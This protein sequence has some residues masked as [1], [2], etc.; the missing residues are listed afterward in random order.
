MKKSVK[1]MAALLC[2]ALSLVVAVPYVGAAQVDPPA[3]EPLWTNT[4]MIDVNIVCIDGVGYAETLVKGKLGTESVTTD[5]Y[6]FRQVGSLWVYVTELHET[7]SGR[8]S[9]VSCPFDTDP[10]ATFLVDFTFTVTRN[11]TDEVIPRTEYYT[12]T[13]P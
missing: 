11:G 5:L 7:D 12:C 6:V 13:C 10:G 4:N 1:L 3:A 8:T 2:I 9:C